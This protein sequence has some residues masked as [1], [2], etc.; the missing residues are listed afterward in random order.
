M[1]AICLLH[2]RVSPSRALRVSSNSVPP[3]TAPR[4]LSSVCA[5]TVASWL[6]PRSGRLLP[7]VV[8]HCRRHET[9][10]CVGTTTMDDTDD[11]HAAITHNAASDA[12]G[13]EAADTERA[14]DTCYGKG[15]AL[16][17]TT[18]CD[19]CGQRF[20]TA[21]C[22]QLV[23]KRRDDSSERPTHQ[24]MLERLPMR[25]ESYTLCVRC[26]TKPVPRDL[27]A[28]PLP[29]MRPSTLPRRS[30]GAHTG[31]AINRWADG[32]KIGDE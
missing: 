30:L 17:A 1:S 2:T 32:R 7:T 5:F 6:H 31:D 9:N 20:C 12:D 19:R 22:R 18:T 8:T 27:P 13:C 25:T 23:L 3:R 29:T 15:C 14:S 4:R 11:P 10:A 16:P 24:G 21:H 28:S 26:R